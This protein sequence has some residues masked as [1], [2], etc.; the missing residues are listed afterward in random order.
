MSILKYIF[1]VLSLLL[2]SSCSDD[3]DNVDIGPDGKIKVDFSQ[4]VWKGT[5]TEHSSDKSYIIQIWFDDDK[6]GHY[7]FKEESGDDESFYNLHTFNYY[8]N[9]RILLISALDWSA[10]SGYWWIIKQKG[11]TL[12]FSS[13]PDSQYASVATLT[14]IQI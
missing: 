6:V 2:I 7:R 10:F 9:G 14:K 12:Y 11:D 3:S 13:E 5:F 4:T 1:C 8:L